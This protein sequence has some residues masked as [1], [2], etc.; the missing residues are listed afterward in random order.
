[1][2]AL[3]QRTLEQL[4]LLQY[5]AGYVYRVS[6]EERYGRE[7]PQDQEMAAAISRAERIMRGAE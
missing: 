3:D 1:M 2:N 7:A 6:R 5:E 4:I